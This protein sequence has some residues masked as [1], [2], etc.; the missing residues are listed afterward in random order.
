V[1]FLGPVLQ[2]D[3]V[4]SGWDR[5]PVPLGADPPTWADAAD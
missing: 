5:A 4:R 3:G 1:R 2:V